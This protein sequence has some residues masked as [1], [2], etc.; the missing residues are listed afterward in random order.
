MS[1]T[2]PQP[3]PQN[4]YVRPIQESDEKIVK[5]LIGQ[6]VMEGLAGANNKFVTNP[7]I[8]FCITAVGLTLNR[9]MSF[10]PDSSNI[11]SWFTPL[12]GPCLILLPVLGLAE[13]Y[14]RPNFSKR[15]RKVIGSLDLI[16]LYNYYNQNNNGGW[17]FIHNKEIIGTILIDSLN[18]GKSLKSVLGNEE[19]EIENDKDILS[20]ENILNRKV[21]SDS[22][23]RTN[24][25]IRKRNVNNDN[26]VKENT[27]NKNKNTVEIRHFDIDSPYRQSSLSLDLL[28]EALNHSFNDTPNSQIDKVIIKVK[29]FS[30]YIEK[31]LSQVG[32]TRLSNEKI[33][34]LKLEVD[35]PEK[36]GLLGWKGYWMILNKQDWLKNKERFQ[37]I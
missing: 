21:D 31:S 7:I 19:G 8:V 26:K 32:F 6:G 10:T 23:T 18:P 14:H 27:T 12:I 16:K 5:M 25:T 13:F 17:V 24:S 34:E 9:Y 33:K 4:D 15:L 29:P 11:L 28:I 3:Q 37:S 20:K 2:N 35:Q 22:N 30:Q 1:K 36:I